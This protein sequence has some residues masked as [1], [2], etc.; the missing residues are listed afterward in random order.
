MIGRIRTAEV[1]GLDYLGASAV[2]PFIVMVLPKVI[3]G[4]RGTAPADLDA[5]HSW[6]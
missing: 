5:P 3:K 1:P 4:S 6:T 2:S